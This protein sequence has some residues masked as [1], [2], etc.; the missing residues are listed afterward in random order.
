M[1][2]EKQMENIIK[3]L[4]GKLNKSSEEIRESV[5]RGNPDS[6][7]NSLN[8]QQRAQVNNL[9]SNPELTKKLMEDKSVQD[10][11]KRLEL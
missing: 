9:L 6:L 10:L 1:A 11:I 3:M 7:L 8:P 2:N 5:N 4:S